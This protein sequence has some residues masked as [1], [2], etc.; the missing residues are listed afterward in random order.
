MIPELQYKD[1][2]TGYSPPIFPSAQS[3]YD[4][5]KQ[6]INSGQQPWPPRS[7][8]ELLLAEELGLTQR[9]PQW[10]PCT[11]GLK[12]LGLPDTFGKVQ[13]PWSERLK[14]GLLSTLVSDSQFRAAIR[15]AIS[16]E[17]EQWA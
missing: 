17:A 5:Y 8:H 1:S 16:Q 3:W 4:A 14:E 10:I 12:L 11:D 9:H 13:P 6:A 2:F 7:R 15:A